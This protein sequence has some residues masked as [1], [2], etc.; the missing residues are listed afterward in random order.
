[1]LGE[2]IYGCHIFITAVTKPIRHRHE[3]AAACKRFFHD[4]L[5]PT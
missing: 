1:M 5:S 2:I 3:I 4:T